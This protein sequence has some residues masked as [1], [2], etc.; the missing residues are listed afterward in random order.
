MESPIKRVLEFSW[1][2]FEIPESC[3]N[4]MVRR[5]ESSGL[6]QSLPL[7]LSQTVIVGHANSETELSSECVG[8]FCF[9]S[10]VNQSIVWTLII[11]A[12]GKTAHLFGLMIF[13]IFSGAISRM[14]LEVLFEQIK[15]YGNTWKELGYSIR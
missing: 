2:V 15:F 5:K 1:N 10:K 6:R 9:P 14:A 12:A 3:P 4:K 13:K 11:E 8:W 7:S